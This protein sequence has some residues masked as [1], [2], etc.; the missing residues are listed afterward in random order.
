M[1]VI[2]IVMVV[3]D[4]SLNL[5]LNRFDD[6]CFFELKCLLQLFATKKHIE[7]DWNLIALEFAFFELIDVD[8]QDMC[9][10]I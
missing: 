5:K 3:V 1:I 10:G 2:V 9:F 7:I 4:V 8:M 6:L